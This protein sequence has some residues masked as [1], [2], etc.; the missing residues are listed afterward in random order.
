MNMESTIKILEALEKDARLTPEQIADQTGVKLSEVKKV[1]K[2]A[3]KDGTIVKYKTVINWSKLG[4]EQ[5]WAIVEVKVSPQRNVGFGAIAERIYNYSQAKA[6]YLASGTFDFAIL[7]AG[8]TMQE[9]GKMSIK[10]VKDFFV[11]LLAQEGFSDFFKQAGGS[12]E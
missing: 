3:E 7:V 8:K 4:E 10:E 9:V 2:K 12:I 6:V 1:I 11:E 5:V